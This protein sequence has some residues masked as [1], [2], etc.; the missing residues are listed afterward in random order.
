MTGC[1]LKEPAKRPRN[2]QS[3]VPLFK[4][5][6]AP[7]ERTGLQFHYAHYCATT[8]LV[9]AIRSGGCELP[10]YHKNGYIEWY[11]SE[12]DLSETKDS[13]AKITDETEELLGCLR[14]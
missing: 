14:S 8:S 9:G 3:L 11:N 12:D 5:S 13:A 2:G 1:Q 6:K 4:D 7:L 10:A